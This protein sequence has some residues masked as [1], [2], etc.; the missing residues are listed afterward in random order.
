[1]MIYNENSVY[2]VQRQN[3]FQNMLTKTNFL[4][5]LLMLIVMYAVKLSW[6]I[7]L[8]DGFREVI[9]FIHDYG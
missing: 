8:Q 5:L 3:A 6:K 4:F 9:H 1:M 7:P 2:R